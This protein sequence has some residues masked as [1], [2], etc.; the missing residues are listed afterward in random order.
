MC[1]HLTTLP[2]CTVALLRYSQ[3]PHLHSLLLQNRLLWSCLYLICALLIYGVRHTISCGGGGNI[4][5]CFL[6]SINSRDGY[7]LVGTGHTPIQ[8][9][10][11]ASPNLLYSSLGRGFFTFHG[12]TENLSIV[13][14][15]L[16]KF[17]AYFELYHSLLERKWWCKR[18]GQCRSGG[19]GE[20]TNLC[21]RSKPSLLSKWTAF[22]QICPQYWCFFGERYVFISLKIGFMY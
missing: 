3:T 11:A 18:K 17:I 16:E 20:R 1:V 7:R 19:G 22:V 9:K 21:G 2:S 13:K 8:N 6:C 4:T 14:Y 5:I 15:M 10:I 12:N